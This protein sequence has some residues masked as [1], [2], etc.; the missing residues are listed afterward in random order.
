MFFVLGVDIPDRFMPPLF[1][2]VIPVYN[3]AHLVRDTLESVFAQTE[4]DYEV[5]C[6]DD[7]ST[8]ESVAVL[9]SYG[10]RLTVIEQANAGPG[11]AR[12]NGI[13]HATGEYVVFLDSDDLWFPWTLATYREAIE[14]HPRPA[15]LGGALFPFRENEEVQQA[16]KGTSALAAYPDYLKA[17]AEGFFVGSCMA[18]ARREAL[19]D[20]GGFTDR[21]IN[22]EDH[23]LAIRIG[24]HP[25]FVFVDSPKMV[26]LRA[27]DGRVSGNAQK[28]IDGVN[29]LLDQ[30]LNGRYP[31][32]GQRAEDRRRILAQH[33]RSL[34]TGL[35]REGHP[36][37]GLA[38]Y[39]RIL[40]WQIRQ[41]RWK[42]VAGL[43]LL[44]LR[45]AITK[46]CAHE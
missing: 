46:R 19:L 15:F 18:A 42:Y 1:S 26:G 16:S 2:V 29:Y 44:A 38:L 12:N 3:R 40:P 27:H 4:T 13:R 23:D 11:A 14:K 7:G 8:D 9:R 32:G 37:A 35:V 36:A 6:V 5:I 24:T 25:G 17:A 22:A 20:I 33:V 31:G 45:Q 34:S 39:G 28:T 21:S 41:G 10:D 30:E 43:P